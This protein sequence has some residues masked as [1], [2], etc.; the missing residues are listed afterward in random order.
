MYH[1]LSH[2]KTFKIEIIFKNSFEFSCKFKTIVHGSTSK[3]HYYMSSVY[4][5]S[6]ITIY[7]FLFK[8]EILIHKSFCHI[9]DF[10]MHF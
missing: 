8:L 4:L 5:L 1:T 9:N 10:T 2:Y 7:T 3:M 6:F